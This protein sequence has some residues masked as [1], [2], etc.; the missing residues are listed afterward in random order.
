MTVSV[1][2]HGWPKKKKNTLVQK[3][4]VANGNEDCKIILKRWG[5]GK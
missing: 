5:L 4:A 3:Q 1:L 2:K